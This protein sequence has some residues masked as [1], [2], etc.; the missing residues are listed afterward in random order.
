MKSRAKRLPR[1]WCALQGL[2][3]LE[4][5]LAAQR[6]ELAWP[7]GEP[8]RVDD[9]TASDSTS[10]LAPRKVGGGDRPLARSSRDEGGGAGR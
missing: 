7:M 2:L 4:A 1:L 8:D 10:F 9:S 6:G 5:C 3:P